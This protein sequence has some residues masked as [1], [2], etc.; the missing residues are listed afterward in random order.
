MINNQTNINNDLNIDDLSLE[1]KLKNEFFSSKLLIVIEKK[2]G[3]KLLVPLLENASINDLYRYVELYYAHITT[4][5]LNIYY[6]MGN[7]SKF[8]PKNDMLMNNFIRNNYIKPFTNYPS[9][10]MFKF[11]LDLCDSHC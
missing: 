2:C 9:N 1:T 5:P 7:S 11:S 6:K 8:L 3:F 4:S 10:V